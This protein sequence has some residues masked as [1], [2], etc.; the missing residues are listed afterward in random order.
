MLDLTALVVS[1][2]LMA[3]QFSEKQ[4]RQTP[5]GK[6]SAQKPLRAATA[7]S[8]RTIAEALEPV[9]ERRSAR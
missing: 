3:E 4:R 8:L 7:R 6:D 1:Q 9:P 2:R 5:V